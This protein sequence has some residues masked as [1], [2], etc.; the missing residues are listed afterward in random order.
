MKE[1]RL[2]V[3]KA[4]KEHKRHPE[5]GQLKKDYNQL[6]N[7]YAKRVKNTRQNYYNDE[8]CKSRDPK[9][10]Y[11]PVK[12]LLGKKKNTALP[13][14]FSNEQLP[15]EFRM[16]YI[17]KVRKLNEMIKEKMETLVIDKDKFKPEDPPCELTHFKEVTKDEIKRIMIKMNDKSNKNDPMPAKFI[18]ECIDEMVPTITTIVNKIISN[19]QYPKA[20][21]EA[22]LTPVLKKAHLS[23]EELG[24]FRPVSQNVFLSK[25]VDKVLHNQLTE[26]ID[27]NNLESVRQ[28]GYKA[29]N[30]TETL[31]IH[32]LTI[33][34][35][36]TT[37]TKSQF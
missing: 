27:D 21:K 17:Q 22:S 15:D 10:L 33:F 11:G 12:I 28:A 36:T 2:L 14:R 25:I 34:S 35:R 18:K 30:S 26:Y 6:R 29:H 23:T 4:H 20:L 5:D 1:Q 7:A 37:M 9:K 24:S 31:L 32:Y 3:A 8:L 19:G 13:T 16:F